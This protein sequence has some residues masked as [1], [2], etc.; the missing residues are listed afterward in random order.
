MKSLYQRK[1]YKITMYSFTLNL[2]TTIK[3]YNVT[4]KTLHL[5]VSQGFSQ[6]I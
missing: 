4:R 2:G 5:A 1:S 3:K 6:E